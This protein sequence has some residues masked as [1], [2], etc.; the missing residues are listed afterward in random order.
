MGYAHIIWFCT[1]VKKNDVIRLTGKWT[2]FKIMENKL[3]VWGYGKGECVCNRL[4]E[5]DYL[6]RPYENLWLLYASSNVHI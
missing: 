1:D 2:E 3:E 4:C 6:K 5:L